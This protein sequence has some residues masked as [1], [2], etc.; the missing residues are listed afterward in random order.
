MFPCNV[1]T[2]KTDV[3]VDVI[4]SHDGASE[5]IDGVGIRYG[6][7]S[8]ACRDPGTKLLPEC[9]LPPGRMYRCSKVIG[10]RFRVNL[11]HTGFL[12]IR[13]LG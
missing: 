2:N 12:C 3:G 4:V 9:D 5:L 10:Q 7:C 8:G 11:W 1:P 6:S 13:L